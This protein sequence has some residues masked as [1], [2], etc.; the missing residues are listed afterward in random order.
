MNALPLRGAILALAPALLTA[1]AAP[2]APSRTRVTVELTG[3][4]L[5][6]GF[7]SSA[8]VNNLDNPQ[9]AESL[10]INPHALGASTRQSRLSLAARSPSVF[11]A[12]FEGKLESD[13]HGGQMPSNDGRAVPLIRLRTATATLRWS[14]ASLLLGQDAPLVSGLDP[15]SP[16]AVGTPLFA[17]AGNLWQWTPQMR[18]GFERVGEL[19]FGAQAAVLAPMSGDAAGTFATGSDIA[20]HTGR[21]FVQGRLYVRWGTDDLVREIGCG[22][23]K[24]WIRPVS[25][26][27][28][29]DA[30]TCDVLL[31]V[32]EMLEL[33]GEVFSGRALSALGGGGI[34][35]NFEPTGSSLSTSGGWVQLNIRP[36][37][38][39]GLGGGCGVDHPDPVAIR[40]RNDV[41]A[42]YTLI[43]PAGP[44]FLG[45][46]YR[47]LRTDYA[48]D[49]FTSHFGT[50]AAGFKF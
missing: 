12:T 27:E 1:Q 36:V 8:R 21:P 30:V 49:R 41:C 28:S 17:N 43:E 48:S 5:T 44:L 11:G 19:R 22:V 50:I 23:H 46:E 18:F 39:W 37:P 9:F 33:R 38:E 14:G 7:Y 15:V 45:A 10:T 16:T 6:N 25:A 34:G 35:Q 31:P 4:I 26:I 42:G 29:T 20:E 3:R 24:G 2:A 47:L 32:T 40:R 13:F